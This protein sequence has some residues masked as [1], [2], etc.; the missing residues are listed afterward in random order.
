RLEGASELSY[1]LG[2]DS[3]DTGSNYD[4]RVSRF[5]NVWEP[6]CLVI[7]RDISAQSRAEVER[8]A[9]IAAEQA[10]WAKDAFLAKLSHELRTPLTPVLAITSAALDQSSLPPG[11]RSSLEIVQRNV[12][13]EARLID[14]L[15]DQSLISLGKLRL[16]TELVD[17]HGL[18]HQS[19]EDCAEFIRDADLI[20]RLDLTATNRRIAA[21]PGRLQQVFRNLIINAARN[22]PA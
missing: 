4:V 1:R 12:H 8:T 21:D 22:S 20:A 14:D 19:L 5:P 11:L 7:I 2:A 18:L 16:R 10:N 13:H 17:A 3:R 6:G 9:R 15:L